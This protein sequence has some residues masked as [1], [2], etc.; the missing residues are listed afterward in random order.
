MTKHT[1]HPDHLADRLDR[2][3]APGKPDIP[4]EAADPLVNAA[5][6]LANAP[7]PEMPA[8]MMARVQ[9]KMMSAN[10]QPLPARVIRPRLNVIHLS[11]LAAVASI[12]L[13]FFLGG[14]M[15]A[16]AD[17]VP[18]DFL[19]PV[20]QAVEQAE[21]TF[22]PSKSARADVYLTHAERRTE[23]AETLLGRLM[24]DSDLVVSA[25][26]NMVQSAELA[27]EAASPTTLQ[28]LEAR[29]ITV[30][31][32]LDGIVQQAENQ[33]LASSE[34]LDSVTTVME[35]TRDSGSLL[36][37][38]P[39]PETDPVIVATDT[40]TPTPTFT[41][42]MTATNTPTPTFTAT[43]TATDT[44]TPTFTATPQP[45]ATDMPTE[46]DTATPVP[47]STPTLTPR[48]G[49]TYSTHGVNVRSGPGLEF[50]I[51]A[52]IKPYTPV[53]VIGE[54][55]N[56]T[57]YNVVL[58]DLRTGWIAASL[59]RFGIPPTPTLQVTLDAAGGDDL[60]P[61][62]LPTTSSNEPLPGGDSEQPS[63]SDNGDS[64]DFGCDHPGTYCNA[65]GQ[66]KDK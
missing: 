11:R 23:E 42:T 38:T 3:L 31:A 28:E 17:S 26:D 43:M 25:L 60:S 7:K 45:T 2:I 1:H 39:T 33:H 24:F 41:A 57:W 21:L 66:N 27:R 10:Q 56:A 22:A 19:Y 37:P 18:G 52:T 62:V 46:T 44:P 40:P 29:T 12:V 59:V 4:A 61:T 49:Y 55:E 36:L 15:P 9:A 20:K 35:T 5:L 32:Q 53:T 13:V 6:R 48:V 47:T 14:L 63:D 8:D 34:M 54:N 64:S 51:I 65:P 50:D 58:P 16:L 30:N